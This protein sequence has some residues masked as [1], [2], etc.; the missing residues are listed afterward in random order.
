MNSKEE[1]NI[2][3]S[4]SINNKMISNEQINSEII[5]ARITMCSND[6]PHNLS[7]FPMAECLMELLDT[8]DKYFNM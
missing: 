7:P 2:S 3:S 5:Q 1:I 4:G 6:V 8:Q